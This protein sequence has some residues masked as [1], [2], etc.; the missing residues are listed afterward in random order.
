MIKLQLNFMGPLEC[1]NVEV[2]IIS[3]W[4]ITRIMAVPSVC[5]ILV[6]FHILHLRL[7]AYFGVTLVSFTVGNYHVFFF[8]V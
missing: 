5:L 6:Y 2:I 4:G 7:L 8:H 3:F 1:R